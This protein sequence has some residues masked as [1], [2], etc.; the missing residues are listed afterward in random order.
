MEQAYTLAV[1]A[2]EEEISN[3]EVA[4]PSN[5][6]QP[7]SSAAQADTAHPAPAKNAPQAHQEA[8]DEPADPAPEHSRHSIDTHP[9]ATQPGPALCPEPR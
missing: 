9:K 8:S 2:A 1:E 5:A 4:T 7:H 3:A 6:V